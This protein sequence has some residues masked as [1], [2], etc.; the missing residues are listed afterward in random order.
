[1]VQI[2]KNLPAMRDSWVPSLGWE[3][4]WRREQLP[5]PVFWPAEFQGRRS[6]AGYSPWGCKELD[7]PE[8]HTVYVIINRLS[9]EKFVLEKN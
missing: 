8:G 1:M 3:D 5:T 7:M 9:Y 4:P 6:L 2:V